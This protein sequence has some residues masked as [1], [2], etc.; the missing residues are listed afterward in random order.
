MNVPKSVIHVAAT[1]LMTAAQAAVTRTP[2]VTILM[3]ALSASED[4]LSKMLPAVV[5]A[6]YFR[7]W[8]SRVLSQESYFEYS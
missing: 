8:L 5:L 1:S 4:E 6:L 2:L 7:G 3:L